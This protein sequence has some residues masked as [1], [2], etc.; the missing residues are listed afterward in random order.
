MQKAVETVKLSPHKTNKIA[1]TFFGL[2]NKTEAQETF[3]T[4]SCNSYPDTIKAYVA[5]GTRFGTRSGYIHAELNAILKR[6]QAWNQASIAITDPPCPNCMKHIASA[7]I[8]NIFIDH[9]GFEKDFFKRR[10]SDFNILS[11]AVAEHSGIS[12]FKVYRKEKKIVP[13]PTEPSKQIENHGFFLVPLEEK[14]SF[15][16]TNKK[17]TG[18][19]VSNVNAQK[20]WAYSHEFSYDEKKN[21]AIP[22]NPLLS[23]RFNLLSS[24][25]SH[26]VL[27]ALKRGLSLDKKSFLLN[28]FPSP[29]EFIFLLKLEAQQIT[30][31]TKE[32]ILTLD[33]SS[34]LKELDKLTKL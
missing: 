23:G 9:K 6:D 17:T 5:S 14:T 12:F 30:I 7:E 11:K 15:Q 20:L 24:P 34:I 13:I 22:L 10:L 26:T 25:L 3:A 29:S 27:G 2:C 18:L 32:K 4:S 19:I 33:Q 31:E 16:N 1:A 28:Y 8:K 21:A